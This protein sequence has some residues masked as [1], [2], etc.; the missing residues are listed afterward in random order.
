MKT[1]NDQRLWV[2]KMGV[3]MEEPRDRHWIGPDQTMMSIEYIGEGKE[4]LLK[5]RDVLEDYFEFC[6]DVRRAHNEGVDTTFA[7][8]PE[9]LMALFAKPAAKKAAPKKEK[10]DAASSSEAQQ[11]S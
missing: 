11:D 9:S 5:F 7:T 10:P 4:E 2:D 8:P 1:A 3:R 6:K